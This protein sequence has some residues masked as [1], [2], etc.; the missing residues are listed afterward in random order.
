MSRALAWL[1]GQGR[2]AFPLAL[3]IGLAVPPVAAAIRPHL[4]L[5]VLA[6]TF[7][8]LLRTDLGA[9]ASL[10]R[11]PAALLA[12]LAATL[13]VSAPIAWGTARLF[14]LDPGLSAAVVITACAPS[15]TSAPAFARIMGLDASFALA[16]AIVGMAITPFTAPPIALSLAGV[17]LALTVEAMMARLGLFVGLPM[18]AAMAARRI[19]PE[20]LA[21]R[22]AATDSLTVGLLCVFAVGVM[23]GVTALALAAPGRAV[24]MLAVAFGL[25]ALLFGLGCLLFAGAGAQRRLTAGLLLGNRQMALMLAVLPEGAPRDVTLFLAVAQLPLYLNPFLLRPLLRRWLPPPP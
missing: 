13:L 14:G 15:I 20:W 10:L 11:R 8:I 23:D 24:E 4:S 1:A 6:M 19:A 7:S 3:A 16:A 25:N 18:L 17:D 22:G 12:V 5:V 21:A 9:A 2:L